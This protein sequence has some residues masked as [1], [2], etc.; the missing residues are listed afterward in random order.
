MRHSILQMASR[1]HVKFIP[2]LLVQNSLCS[3]ASQIGSRLGL[4]IYIYAVYIKKIT[5]VQ[6]V[7][8]M[9]RFNGKC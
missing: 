8:D 4:F 1:S 2:L 7:Q 6:V 5:W 9:T 3:L